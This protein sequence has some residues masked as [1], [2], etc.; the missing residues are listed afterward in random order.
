MT[1]SWWE[2]EEILRQFGKWLTRTEE[3]IETLGDDCADAPADKRSEADADMLAP[4]LPDVGL[5]QLVEA[6]SAMRHE[7]KLYTKGTRNLEA[8]V[9]RSLEGLDLASRTFESVQAKEQEA[10]LRAALPMVEALVG[11]DEGLLRAEQAFRAAHR[12]LTQMAPARLREDLDRQLASQSWW[13]RLMLRR[14]HERVRDLACAALGQTADAEFASLMEGFQMIQARLTR[15]MS[16][17]RIERIDETGGRVDPT[18]MTVVELVSD[19]VLPAETV[20]EVVR[21]G[22]LWSDHVVRFA[23]VRAVARRTTGF[24]AGVDVVN[25]A[26][27]ANESADEEC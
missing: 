5:L 21:S 17:Q 3:E 11:L 25:H 10:A 6:F 19:Q 12:Q 23:E 15:A 26:A 8:T 2:N 18:R 20:V 22:Y 24:D 13:R 7:L 4:D 14:W 16:D 27:G 9:T 1:R